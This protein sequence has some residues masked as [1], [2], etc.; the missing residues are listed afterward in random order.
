MMLEML[1]T[2]LVQGRNA[3]RSGNHASDDGGDPF[4]CVRSR[5]DAEAAARNGGPGA[6]D[7]RPQGLLLHPR[8]FRILEPVGD[9]VGP[10]DLTAYMSRRARH[11]DQP[12]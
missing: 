7:H 5:R 1:L 3:E 8:G 6:D 4:G 11:G 2:F 12:Q 9:F 10:L